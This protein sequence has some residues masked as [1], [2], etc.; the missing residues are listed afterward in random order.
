MAAEVPLHSRIPI[1][2]EM[3]GGEGPGPGMSEQGQ[4]RREAVGLDK[5]LIAGTL[6]TV[7]LAQRN[8]AI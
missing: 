8:A 5:A 4:K 6:G 7:E 1:A 3:M 2:G